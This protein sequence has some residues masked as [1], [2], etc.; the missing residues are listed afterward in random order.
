MDPGNQAGGALEIL[1]HEGS[2]VIASWIGPGGE[3][4]PLEKALAAAYRV[5]REPYADRLGL[6]ARSL[7]WTVYRQAVNKHGS[8]TSTGRSTAPPPCS[9]LWRN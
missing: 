8:H 9:A 6:Y 5:R 3:E 2:H 7:A 1:F 4:G